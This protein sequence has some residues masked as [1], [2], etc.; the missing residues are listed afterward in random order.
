[1]KYF[2]NILEGEANRISLINIQQTST[3]FLRT[4]DVLLKED[5]LSTCQN[6]LRRFLQPLHHTK[7]VNGKMIFVSEGLE[8]SIVRITMFSVQ[9]PTGYQKGPDCVNHLQKFAASFHGT[10]FSHTEYYSRHF[11]DHSRVV[12]QFERHLATQITAQE[13]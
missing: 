10:S 2:Q 1:M 12:Y 11:R 6:R 7:V 13:S 3:L 9:G 5:K 8:F 4:G